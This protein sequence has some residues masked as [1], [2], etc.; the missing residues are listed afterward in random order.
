MDSLFY[1][2]TRAEF[3]KVAHDFAQ[4]NAIPYPFQTGAAGLVGF[5]T[6]HPGITMRS[7]EPTSIARTRGF[8]RPQVTHFYTLLP[9]L[10]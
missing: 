1:G 6:K 9:E 3:K 8:S 5:I 10:I 2:L 7:P 4:K